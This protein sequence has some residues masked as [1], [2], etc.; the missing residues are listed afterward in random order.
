MMLSDRSDRDD[1]AAGRLAVVS[2][3][4]G[5][6]EPLDIWAVSPT[7]R[8]VPP[9]VRLFVQAVLGALDDR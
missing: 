3:A 9:K 1:M 5:A 4:E 8:L 6:P 7:V 2:P